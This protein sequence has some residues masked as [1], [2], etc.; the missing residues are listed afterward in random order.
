MPGRTHPFSRGRVREPHIKE[1]KEV[2]EDR[3][4]EYN[5]KRSKMLW[6]IKDEKESDPSVEVIQFV[7]TFD[8]VLPELKLDKEC[9][10]KLKL[11]LNKKQYQRVCR[12]HSHGFCKHG[13]SCHFYHSHV[14]CEEHLKEGYCSKR[15]CTDWH[16][17]TCRFY[18]GRIGCKKEACAYLHR[19]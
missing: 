17:Y 16:R 3:K 7:D 2:I 5:S 18:S 4:E 15:A 10:I 12:Y 1:E 19:K 9:E 13:S 6:L 14:D 11:P 8:N